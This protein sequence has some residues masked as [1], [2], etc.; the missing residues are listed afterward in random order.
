MGFANNRGVFFLNHKLRQIQGKIYVTYRE[1]LLKLHLCR[2]PSIHYIGGSDI[3]PPPLPKDQEQHA[4]DALECGDE[5]AKNLLIEHNLR[6]VVYIARRFEN[7]GVGHQ[8]SLY[9]QSHLINILTAHQRIHPFF[10]RPLK[11]RSTL[12]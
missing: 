6:L 8:S 4:L 7:T 9:L 10:Y 11:Y 5:Q 12:E 1:V 2:P 3:L